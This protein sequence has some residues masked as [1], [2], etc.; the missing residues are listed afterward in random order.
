[1]VHI[2]NG[3]DDNGSHSIP[4]D[5]RCMGIISCDVKREK[6]CIYTILKLR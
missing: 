4:H 2:S 6:K 3:K 1:M 5:Y